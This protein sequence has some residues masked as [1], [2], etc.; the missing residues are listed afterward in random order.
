ME[1]I[2]IKTLRRKYKDLL[3]EKVILK[4]KYNNNNDF[5]KL[6]IFNSR[7]DRDFD[8]QNYKLLKSIFLNNKKD[9]SK[10]G[11]VIKRLASYIIYLKNFK[12]YHYI[13]Y[14]N[15]TKTIFIDLIR[16]L[17]QLIDIFLM[18]I[19][20]LISSIK[21]TIENLLFE[22]DYL[23]NK[24]I[25]SI[26]YYNKK[27]GDSAKYYYPGINKQ[28]NNKVFI[29][30]FADSRLFSYSVFLSIFNKKFLSPINTLGLKGFIISLIQFLVLYFYDLFKALFSK[31]NSFIRFW[32]GWKISAEIFYSLLI[33]NSIISLV[34]KSKKCEFISWYENQITLRAFSSGVNYAIKK[35][36]SSSFLSTYNGTP[37][38]MKNKKQYLPIREEINQG[39]WGKIYY[40]QDKNSLNEMETYLKKNNISISLRVVPRS[41]IRMSLDKKI[42]TGENS[43]RIFTIFTHNSY[44]D[45]IAC[46]LAIFNTSND[47]C[48][49]LRKNIENKKIIYIRLHPSLNKYKSLKIINS[50]KEIP[51]YVNYFFIE[52]KE[53]SIIESMKISS[54]SIF[55]LSPYINVALEIK[56]NVISVDSNHINSPPIRSEFKNISNLIKISP[57]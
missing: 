41:M 36:N 48:F 23:V 12:E 50:L 19:I 44:W 33:Y 8:I 5:L 3:K 52:N 43:R 21:N 10:K 55:G 49:R 51:T 57:W 22:N 4:K 37:F 15:I 39:F 46:L 56:S 45:L 28:K 7:D 16:Y 40:L 35:Y 11:I 47:E 42:K 54:Y 9:I 13:S 25:Y 6:S 26:Y 24:K 27:M 38:T 31:K 14:L 17:R 53:E 32:F 2:S 30:S 20:F 1:K 29:I 18:I 34:K